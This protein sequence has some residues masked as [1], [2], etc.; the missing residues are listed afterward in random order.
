[1]TTLKPCEYLT[2]EYLK[3]ILT[4][5]RKPTETLWGMSF[6]LVGVST[7]VLCI[8]LVA[9]KKIPI[10][11]YAIIMI[12][13]VVMVY[14]TVRLVVENKRLDEEEKNRGTAQDEAVKSEETA[15]ELKDLPKEEKEAD[16]AEEEAE[17]HTNRE[18]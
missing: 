6:T 15:E 9:K 1:M 4:M 12:A 14:Y 3:G 8:M 10:A 7:I 11:L 13:I 5:K 16:E 18:A 17:N 2:C